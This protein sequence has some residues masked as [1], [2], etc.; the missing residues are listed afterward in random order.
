MSDIA[1]LLGVELGEKFTVKGIDD[2]D[3][4]IQAYLTKDGMMLLDVYMY[5]GDSHKY[6][7]RLITG[8]LEFKKLPWEPKYNELYYWPSVFNK[9]VNCSYWYRDTCDYSLKALGMVY[10]TKAEAQKNF[11]KD[12]EKLTGKKLG[13]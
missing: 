2:R 8:K 11:A 13:E 12:Y 7:A 9:E 4:W 1:K 6:L 3:D 5:N 10:H